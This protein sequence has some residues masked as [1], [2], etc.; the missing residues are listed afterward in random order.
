[1]KDEIM[2]DHDTGLADSTDLAQEINWDLEHSR[3]EKRLAA[4][5]LEALKLIVAWLAI[6]LVASMFQFAQAL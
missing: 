4:A 1:M 3:L 6:G 5:R 2:S